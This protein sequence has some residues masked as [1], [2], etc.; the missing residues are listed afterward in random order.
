MFASSM[1]LGAIIKK[2]KEYKAGLGGG[3]GAKQKPTSPVVDPRG[4][5]PIKMR[6][7]NEFAAL[8]ITG[9]KRR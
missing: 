4:A 6:R 8:S 2:V 9:P 1:G 3:V 5:L 7:G